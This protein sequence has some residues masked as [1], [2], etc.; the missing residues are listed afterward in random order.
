[1]I[2]TSEITGEV[3]NFREIAEEI[4]VE[5]QKKES[6]KLKMFQRLLD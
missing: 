3:T 5:I 1:M 2:N 6:K 4:S